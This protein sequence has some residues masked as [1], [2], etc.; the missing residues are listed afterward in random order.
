MFGLGRCSSNVQAALGRCAPTERRTEFEEYLGAQASYGEGLMGMMG[1]ADSLRKR[2]AMPATHEDENEEQRFAQ[3]KVELFS[4]FTR[5]V[6]EWN[7]L[8]RPGATHSLQHSVL[9]ILTADWSLYMD[10]SSDQ[11]E[12]QVALEVQ[13]ILDMITIPAAQSLRASVRDT[14]HDWQEQSTN[15]RFVAAHRALG[16]GVT[17]ISIRACAE[18]LAALKNFK[19]L[20]ED[21]LVRAV[22]VACATMEAITPEMGDVMDLSVPILEFV[23]SDDRVAKPEVLERCE[24]VPGNVIEKCGAFTRVYRALGALRAAMA[25]HSGAASTAGACGIQVDQLRDSYRVAH[26]MLLEPPRASAPWAA[27]YNN[28]CTAALQSTDAM[29]PRLNE[30][31]TAVG[32]A[33]L[34]ELRLKTELLAQV[35]GGGPNGTHWLANSKGDVIQWFKKTLDKV[36]KKQ[37]DDFQTKAAKVALS[38]YSPPPQTWVAPTCC[39]LGP[40]AQE[41]KSAGTQTRQRSLRNIRSTPPCIVLHSPPTNQNILERLGDCWG[42][43]ENIL[44]QTRHT[45]RPHSDIFGL[46]QNTLRHLGH[47]RNDRGTPIKNPQTCWNEWRKLGLRGQFCGESVFLT[48]LSCFPML[49]WRVE[50]FVTPDFARDLPQDFQYVLRTSKKFPNMS[51]NTQEFPMRSTRA[52]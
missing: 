8:F 10:S 20:T 32:E 11:R 15:A 50:S 2:M 26:D 19:T 5:H 9:D 37:I 23:V 45:T 33:L 47:S 13:K 17:E 41:R 38:G 42:L 28:F 43:P 35:S 48:H 1:V 12:I 51:K 18:A 29:L 49:S 34:Q 27:Q 21:E 31:A 22:E 16:A 25:L 4:N 44:E 52:F 40:A 14:L 6:E 30:A 3:E 24:G 36:D 46:S 39:V 7:S